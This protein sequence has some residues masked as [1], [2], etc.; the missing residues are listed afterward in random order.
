MLTVKTITSATTGRWLSDGIARGAGALLFRKTAKGTIPIY[1]RYTRPDGSRDTLAIGVF[2]ELGRNGMTLAEA[3]AKAGELSKLYQSG[4]RDIRAHLEDEARLRETSRE[5]RKALE[6][7]RKAEDE[8]RAK[9]TLNA[10]F[11]VYVASLERAGKTASSKAAATAF[12]NHVLGPFPEVATTLANEVT[13]HQIATLIRRVREAGKNRMAG[14]L[15]SYLSAAF[16]AAMRAPYDSSLPDSFVPFR[17]V[18]NPVE[19]I[20]TI[21]VHAGDRTLSREELRRYVTALTL[22]RTPEGLIGNGPAIALVGNGPAIALVD[23]CLLL[24]L[25]SGGQRIAQ[26]LRVTEQDWNSDANILRLW[27]G[28]GRRTSAREHLLPVGPWAVDVIESLLPA[29][30]SV[31]RMEDA[32][33]APRL[34]FTSRMGA[35]VSPSTPGKR[36]SEIAEQLNGAPFTVRDIRRTVE[37]MLARMGVSRDIRAQLLS[38]GLA[39]V[40]NRHYD[41]HEY[42]DEKR[43]VLERWEEEVRKIVREG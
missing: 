17:V 7:T 40:Q 36:V 14:V 6:E 35:P 12:R 41:R 2:D 13:P 4:E 5:T 31:E 10:L 30:R 23:R 9:N 18:G 8:A 39:G 16:T 25:L 34:L 42:L 37:T 19:V 32:D 21:P 43:A 33:A 28:K 20:P 38:H 3:R 1:F 29:L 24:A 15:R 27:D 26:L 22:R 11:S